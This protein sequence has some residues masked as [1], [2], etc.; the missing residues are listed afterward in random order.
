[1]MKNLTLIAIIAAFLL[2]K[3]AVAQNDT[4]SIN[5]E[6][7]RVSITSNQIDCVNQQNGTAKTYLAL[8]LTNN[9]DQEISVSFKKNMWYDG[10][11]ISCESASDEYNV[12]RKMLP[13]ETLVGSCDDNQDLNIFMRMMELEGVRQLTHAE[14]ENINSVEL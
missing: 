13:N 11:C 2:V 14:L 12:S 5:H 8:S 6:D 10:N 1:M 3:N 9:S 7:E 4:F